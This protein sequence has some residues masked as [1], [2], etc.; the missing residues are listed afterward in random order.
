MRFYVR[1]MSALS[2]LMFHL[3]RP[4]RS[5]SHNC[6]YTLSLIL[7]NVHL[8]FLKKM[9]EFATRKSHFLFDGNLYDEINNVAMGS[10]LGKVLPNIFIC[11]FEEKWIQNSKDCPPIWFRS[12]NDTFT[13]FQNKEAAEKFLRYIN[14]RHTNIKF[15][16]ELQMKNQIPF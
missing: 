1:L 6:T 15:T 9:L 7:Q 11:H 12:V 16:V 8:T 2:S 13:L 14:N 3:T 5:S 10:P 4:Y